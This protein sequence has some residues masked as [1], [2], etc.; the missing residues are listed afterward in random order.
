MP[1]WV[2]LDEEDYGYPDF[3]H[4][5][6][7]WS[8]DW[9]EPQIEDYDAGSE[10]EAL[11]PLATPQPAASVLTAAEER[12]ERARRRSSRGA[13]LERMEKEKEYEEEGETT[14]QENGTMKP[15]KADKAKKAAAESDDEDTS[16][17]AYPICYKFM[18]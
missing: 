13:E 18:L 3:E 9:V 12:R 2:V 10:E 15:Q 6:G 8:T 7:N 14:A 17:E 16:D 11:V 5:R 4:A 1:S